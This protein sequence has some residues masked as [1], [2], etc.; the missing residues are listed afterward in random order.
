MIPLHYCTTTTTGTTNDTVVVE[1][2]GLF[3]SNR[4]DVLATVAIVS[5]CM[6]IS[7]AVSDLGIVAAMTG[8]IG[9]TYVVFSFVP[10]P[11]CCSCFF[12]CIID[13]VQLF[14]N[15]FRSLGY[16][17]PGFLFWK[18]A[19]S[20]ANTSKMQSLFHAPAPGGVLAST[21]GMRKGAVALLVLGVILMP[22]GVALTLISSP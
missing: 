15:F 14:S 18:I 19:G 2:K 1:T 3:I 20:S 17:L 16:I 5:I 6:S 22:A 4:V 8:A 12:Q 10:S 13:F 11:H 9:A 7:L 21:A